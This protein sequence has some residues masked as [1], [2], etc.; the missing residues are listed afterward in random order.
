[1]PRPR[2]RVATQRPRYVSSATCSGPVMPPSIASCLMLVS[3]HRPDAIVMFGLAARTP[4][5]RIE[6]IARNRRSVQLPD[7]DWRRRYDLDNRIQAHRRQSPAEAP[8]FAIAPWRSSGHG[9]AAACSQRCRPRTCATTPIGR[10]FAWPNS[11]CGARGVDLRA[12]AERGLLAKTLG[13]PGDGEWRDPTGL[14]RIEASGS[15]AGRR[16]DP[17][18]CR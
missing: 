13:P 17:A 14:R 11:H 3:R 12:R 7:I 4:H 2:P 6:R 9:T 8:F 15:A 1:M 18:H 16:G 5:I 10:R